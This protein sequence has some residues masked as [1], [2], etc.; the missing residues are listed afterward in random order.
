MLALGGC[1]EASEDYT[2]RFAAASNAEESVREYSFAVLPLYNPR[3]LD[4]RY[5]PL[6]AHLNA[7]VRGARFRLVSSRDYDSFDAGLRSQRFDFA[8]ANP[9]QTLMATAH[10]YRVFAKEGGDERFQGLILV[11]KDSPIASVGE[12]RGKTISYPAATAV[13]AAMMPQYFLH[14]HGVSLDKT[15]TLYVGSQDSSIETVYRGTS[16]AAASWVPAWADYQREHPE[17][18]AELTVKWRTAPLVNNGLV[19][20]RAVPGEVADQ[21]RTV[22]ESLEGEPAG[23]ALLERMSISDFDAASERT[24]APVTAFLRAFDAA[25]RP[26]EL[27]E[28]QR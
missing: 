23:Q 28:T 16:S 3:E 27:P 9:Y 19:V 20:R 14:T 15:R 13:A 18:A 10:E 4:E 17:K 11:R 22:L 25:V 26:R 7:K 6:I 5:E 2:P 1:I 8:L 24:Y 21:V 12:L